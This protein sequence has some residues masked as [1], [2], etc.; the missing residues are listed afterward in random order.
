MYSY[1]QGTACYLD[2][3]E[4]TNAYT[5]QGDSFLL[6]VLDLFFNTP[7]KQDSKTMTG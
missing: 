6:L 4:N 2:G 5:F 7:E 1:L 3:E